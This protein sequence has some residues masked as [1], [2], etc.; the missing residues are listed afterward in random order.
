M[1]LY[2][3]KDF[4]I[5]YIFIFISRERRRDI[6]NRNWATNPKLV[7]EKILAFLTTDIQ[8]FYTYPEKDKTM[9]KSKLDDE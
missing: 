5:Y 2:K 3:K 8:Y 1:N 4:N 6:S 7:E 9:S